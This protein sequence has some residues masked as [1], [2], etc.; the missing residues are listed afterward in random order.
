M[1]GG[2]CLYLQSSKV[3]PGDARA[4]RLRSSSL[5]R[6]TWRSWNRMVS[7]LSPAGRLSLTAGGGDEAEPLPGGEPATVS[8]SPGAR[9]AHC[10]RNTRDRKERKTL[11]SQYKHTRVYP[12]ISSVRCIR[13]DS[14]W[15]W[16][17]IWFSCVSFWGIEFYYRCRPATADIWLELQRL[18][19]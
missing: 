13:G 2:G 12:F 1:V 8:M 7:R 5:S 11:T 19:T 9:A 15:T 4:K 10:H 6:V 16:W 3:V 18:A 14:N 17:L